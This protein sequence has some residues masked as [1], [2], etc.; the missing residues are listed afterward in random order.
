MK[1]SVILCKIA[2]F[3]LI[4]C[5]LD[6]W[7]IMF[8][9]SLEYISQKLPVGYVS[10]E[11]EAREVFAEVKATEPA[12]STEPTAS[13]EAAEN[14]SVVDDTVDI[15]LNFMGDCTL[16]TYCGEFTE[17]RFNETAERVEPEYFFEGVRNI[18]DE[19]TFNVTNCEGVFTDNPLEEIYKD[20]SPAFWFK[21][22]AKNARVFSKNA[23]DIVG[24]ANNHVGDYG[25]EGICDTKNALEKNGVRWSDIS[26]PVLLEY[27]GIK[28]V[29][30]C[31]AMWDDGMPDQLI[32]QIA[33][34]SESTDLQIVFYH[35]GTENVHQPDE[36]KVDYCHRFVDA[37][38]DLVVGSHP[39]VL[40][41]LERY[42]G[43]NIVYS[44]GNFVY[45]GHTAPENRTIVYQHK[46]T[47][48]DGK[49]KD[50]NE[51]IFPC[52][53]Y[54]GEMNAFQPV[55]IDDNDDR[56][57]VLDFMYGETDTPF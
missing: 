16:G 17:N 25:V 12:V 6:S 43:V 19:G 5:I 54:T 40:Q 47:F 52:Y 28:M 39:H 37:G 48:K 49:L 3:P 13:T 57:R 33:Q 35:G 44:L 7:V 34:Y 26:N 15:T 51:E 29:I 18:L 55:L 21:S 45:G 27:D 53:I 22:P 9:N 23:I 10:A 8:S 20:Y 14:K 1:K 38:A 30:F 36:Y 42:D 2:L 41:P 24:I 4:M 32:S 31:V 46:F 11:E 56:Q 50:S